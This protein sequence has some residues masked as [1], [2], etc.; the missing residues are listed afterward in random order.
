MRVLLAL[1]AL[2]CAALAPVAAVGPTPGSFTQGSTLGFY[3]NLTDSEVM[4]GGRQ[5]E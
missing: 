2:A 1:A 5:R 3:Q 4:R